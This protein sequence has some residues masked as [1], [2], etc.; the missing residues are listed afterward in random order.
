MSD[1]LILHVKKKWFDKIKSGEKD[2]EYRV[3]SEYWTKRL[4]GREYD[5][6]AIV[7]GYP[8]FEREPE[9]VI[10]FPWNGFVER[11]IIHDEF[12]DEYIDVYAI[13]LKNGGL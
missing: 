6:I 11:R 10:F 1:I 13:R 3:R 12:G 4:L 7:L 5:K 9:K 2:Y 8:N